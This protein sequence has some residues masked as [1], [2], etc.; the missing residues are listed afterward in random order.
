[1][2]YKNSS[3]ILFPRMGQSNDE[4]IFIIIL[5]VPGQSKYEIWLKEMEI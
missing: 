2:V 1:V 3:R 5:I 4:K